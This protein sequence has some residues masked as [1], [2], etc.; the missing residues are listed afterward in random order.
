M[1]LYDYS[2]KSSKGDLYVYS[3]KKGEKIDEDVS[4]VFYIKRTGEDLYGYDAWFEAE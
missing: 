2:E 1:Y 3:G 4:E